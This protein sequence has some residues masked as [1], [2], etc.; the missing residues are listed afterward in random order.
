M[1]GARRKDLR[2]AWVIGGIGL[3]D[4]AR[5][6][7]ITFRAFKKAYLRAYRGNGQ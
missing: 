4:E 1:R 3:R 5:A 2:R 7:Y 6:N